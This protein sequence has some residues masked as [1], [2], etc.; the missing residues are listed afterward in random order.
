MG[1]KSAYSGRPW[2][3]DMLP[4]QGRVQAL[5]AASQTAPS[6]SIE[7]MGRETR[8]QEAERAVGRVDMLRGWNA[9]RRRIRDTDSKQTSSW[10]LQQVLKTETGEWMQENGSTNICHALDDA[11]YYAAFLDLT[12]ESKPPKTF[13]IGTAGPCV[14]ARQ[15][16]D[17]S[18][19]STAMRCTTTTCASTLPVDC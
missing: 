9:I 16:S 1:S 14:Q 13:S 12:D 17:L 18:I 3:D 10:G 4:V 2:Q 11:R 5:H 6:R 8:E 15:R 19:R 7:K